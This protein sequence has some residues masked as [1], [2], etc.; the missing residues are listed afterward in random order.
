M[1]VFFW[2]VFFNVISKTKKHI[3]MS[4]ETY[5]GNWNVIK[6]KLKQSYANL[7]ED[8]VAYA[9]GKEDELLGRIQQKVGKTKQ[10][11]KDQIDSWL[12]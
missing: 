2:R 3:V 11:L 10:E 9:E 1:I 8:D 5:K 7:T 6:G 4:H 12:K